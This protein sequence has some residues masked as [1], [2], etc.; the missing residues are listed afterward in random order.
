MDIFLVKVVLD[1]SLDTIVDC[2]LCIV[3]QNSDW[4]SLALVGNL[5]VHCSLCTKNIVVSTT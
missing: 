3:L 1:V 5:S 2:I 4:G